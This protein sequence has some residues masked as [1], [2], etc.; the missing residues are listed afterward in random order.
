MSLTKE[1]R[2]ELWE[3]LEELKTDIRIHERE[4]ARRPLEEILEEK[5]NAARYLMA[6]TIGLA[7]SNAAIERLR[8]G[9]S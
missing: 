8:R 6:T 3:K 7:K 1:E 4:R 5:A 2:L 9:D